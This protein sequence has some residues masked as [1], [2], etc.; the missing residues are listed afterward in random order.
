MRNQ[1][2]LRNGFPSY[3]TTTRRQ[4]PFTGS[5]RTEP[6]AGNWTVFELEP[7]EPDIEPEPAELGS[8][9]VLFSENP[10]SK[11]NPKIHPKSTN[12]TPPSPSQI[13]EFH[14]PTPLKVEGWGALGAPGCSP[15]F[16][17]GWRNVLL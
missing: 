15:L 16:L 4:P 6:G 14:T 3:D 12:N 5:F 2:L 7:A 13:R 1:D 8:E 17:A 9:E 10:K 11:T